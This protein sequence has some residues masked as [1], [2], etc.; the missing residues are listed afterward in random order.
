MPHFDP[1]SLQIVVAAVVGV[2]LLLQVILLFAI[3][4][5]V[6]KAAIAVREDID[7]IRSSITPLLTDSHELLVRVGPKIEATTDDLAAFTHALREQTN[8]VQ[9]TVTEISERARHQAGRID[10]MVTSALDKA[11]HAGAI[12][13]DVVTKPLRQITGVMAWLRAVV[14]T[15]RAPQSPGPKPPVEGKGD[16]GMFV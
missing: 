6:R 15:M 2:T 9:T 5:G 7:Q 14:E 16:S 12:V 4:V 8:N 10:F 1:Q 3:L 11:D 13:N